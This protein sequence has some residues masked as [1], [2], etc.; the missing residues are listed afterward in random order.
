MTTVTIEK[1][2][3]VPI[4]PST[5]DRYGLSPNVPIRIVET[6]AGVLLVPLTNEPPC[7]ELAKEIAEWQSLGT[8]TLEAF[9][10]EEDE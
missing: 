3:S 1:Q 6:R 2:G 10:Y 9:P 7:A 8:D 4:P 5:R